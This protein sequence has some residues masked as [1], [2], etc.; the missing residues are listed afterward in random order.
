ML[1]H[2]HGLRGGRV[3]AVGALDGAVDVPAQ[4]RELGQLLRGHLVAR[5]RQRDVER[6]LHDRR[7]LREDHDAVGEVDGL[8]DVVRDEQDRDAVVVADLQHE[9]LEVGARLRVDGGERLVHQQDLG[10]VGEPAG[11]RHALLHAARE[12]PRVLV[13]EAVEADRARAPARPSA[14]ARAW[15]A[16]CAA[17]GT[18]R[19][20]RRSSTGTASG[21]SP[22]RRAPSARAAR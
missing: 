1:A 3:G 4:L 17:A 20:R 14:G 5:A 7:A 10:P 13:G 15:R 9:V 2:A 21:C 19:W 11:D 22:G 18:R 16:A 6:L 8:V 12:L